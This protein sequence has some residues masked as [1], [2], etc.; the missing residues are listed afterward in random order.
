MDWTK[1]LDVTLPW[2]IVLGSAFIGFSIC[3]AA[4]APKQRYALVPTVTGAAY[5]IDQQTG[6]ML[7]CAGYQC[8]AVAL[9][10]SDL[11]VPDIEAANRALD[12]LNSN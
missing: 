10:Y 1:V 3:I 7:F 5:R 2:A 8:R 12:Q 9:G 4:D 11:A 6:R